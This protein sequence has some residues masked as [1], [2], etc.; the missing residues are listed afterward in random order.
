VASVRKCVL[1]TT[2]I[3]LNRCEASRPIEP[4]IRSRLPGALGDGSA[5][6]TSL[7]PGRQNG[8]GSPV[9]QDGDIG[10]D[11]N[12]SRDLAALAERKDADANADGP[13]GCQ[14]PHAR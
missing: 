13:D 2:S 5:W 6:L 10:Q 7:H 4:S 11:A 8:Y 12:C 14:Q 3:T 1:P 9:S